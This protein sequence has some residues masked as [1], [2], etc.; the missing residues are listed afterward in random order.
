MKIAGIESLGVY[1]GAASL[2]AKLL[3]EHRNLDID[4]V[5]NNLIIREK[6]VALP[7]E[8]PV[9]NAVNAAKTVVDKLSPEEKARID[10]V[11][12]CTE[13]GVDMAKSVSSY[14][15]Y[16]LELDKNCRIFE[17]KQACYAGTAGLQMALNSV[18]SNLMPGAKALVICTDIY[19]M[20]NH[21]KD[22]EGA[23]Y[24]EPNT[25]VGAV[26]LLISDTPEVLSF[27]LGANG[28]YGYEVWDSAQPK[29]DF[30]YGNADLSLLTYMD[31]V[32]GSFLEYQKRV[33]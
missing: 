13:S 3:G 24:Y 14:V 12:T 31:A 2:S 21:Y 23:A 30:H 9:S 19:R 25:G 11:I 1:L 8:D 16:Y 20:L 27:D 17:L 15:H 22:E 26:A 6:S 32:E 4:R 18:V 28:Y 7:F 5:I 29:P 10:M 33:S